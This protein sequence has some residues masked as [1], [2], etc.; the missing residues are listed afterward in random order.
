[1]HFGSR[2]LWPRGPY[3]TCIFLNFHVLKPWFSQIGSWATKFRSNL[4]KVSELSHCWLLWTVY[5]ARHCDKSIHRLPKN[6]FHHDDVIILPVPILPETSRIE[7][8][9]PFF[10]YIF[11]TT[12]W[13]DGIT[14]VTSTS[15]VELSNSFYKCFL[16]SSRQLPPW[17][18]LSTLLCQILTFVIKVFPVTTLA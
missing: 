6:C 3:S 14:A 10:F 5:F 7:H 15:L 16:G 9:E 8:F 4:R 18:Q 11:P 1:M 12:F 17:N 2:Y 13:L